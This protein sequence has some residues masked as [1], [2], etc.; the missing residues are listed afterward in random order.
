MNRSDSEL[1]QAL[2]SYLAAVEAGDPSTW[3][4]WRPSTR[5]SLMQLRSCLGVLRLAG[6][7]E[8]DDGA[9][10]DMARMTASRQTRGWAISGFSAP[11]AGAAWGSSTRPSKS[12]STVAWP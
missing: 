10:V 6:R 4:G 11:S 7:V 3:S 9:D 5:R 2:E 12:R 1:A 8:G